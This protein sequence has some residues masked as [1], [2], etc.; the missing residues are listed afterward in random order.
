[1]NK[2]DYLRQLRTANCNA[3]LGMVT[4]VQGEYIWSLEETIEQLEEALKLACD[5]LMAAKIL[6]R[7]LEDKVRERSVSA[8]E[9]R[10]LKKIN[11]YLYER[12]DSLEKAIGKA[13]DD[14]GN[15][16]DILREGVR[17]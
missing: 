6:V 7:K 14:A 11:Q 8:I 9:N 16:Q 5:E 4:R 3:D 15:W 1:M 12:V 13:L 17:R 10:E 2:Q